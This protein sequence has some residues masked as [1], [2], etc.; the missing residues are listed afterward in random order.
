MFH[1]FSTEQINELR[2][3]VLIDGNYIRCTGYTLTHKVDEVPILELEIPIVQEIKD[4]Y[5]VVKVSNKEEIANLMDLNEFNEF[6]K[7][8]NELHIKT[9]KEL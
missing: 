9:N 5:V 7:I 2:E 8:W 4:Q 6:C 1:K 3:R